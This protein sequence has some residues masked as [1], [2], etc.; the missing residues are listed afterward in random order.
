MRHFNVVVEVALPR[1][2][3]VESSQFGHMAGYFVNV[4]AWAEVPE[5]A[6]GLAREV[7]L[8]PDAESS[9]VPPEGSIVAGCEVEETSVEE[10]PPTS[11]RIGFVSGRAFYPRKRSWHFWR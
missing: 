11:A 10:D 7:A 9:W 5:Q 8:R 6:E 3:R 2:A 4:G 1:T